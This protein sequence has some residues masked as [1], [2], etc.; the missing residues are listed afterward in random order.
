MRV[1]VCVLGG[2]GVTLNQSRK[3]T[4][5]GVFT[6]FSKKQRHED[7]GGGRVNVHE[8][9]G[10]SA[11]VPWGSRVGGWAGGRRTR[12]VL[13]RH[14]LPAHVCVCVCVCVCTAS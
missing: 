6:C 7:G 9:R 5:G 3:E 12:R 13:C 8:E 4:G 11:L 2:G 14:V 1:S 10:V